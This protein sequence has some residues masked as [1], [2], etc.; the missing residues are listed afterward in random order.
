MTSEEK[1]SNS[2][3][4]VREQPINEKTDSET[5]YNN[6]LKQPIFPESEP[7][8]PTSSANESTATDS[9]TENDSIGHLIAFGGPQR[10]DTDSSIENVTGQNN[11]INVKT[12]SPIKKQSNN[13]H[14][15][16]KGIQFKLPSKKRTQK[17]I[18]RKKIQQRLKDELESDGHDV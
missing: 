14:T 11:K 9:G 1:S 4:S 16:D 15:T 5:E 17:L 13:Y 6:Y 7:E 12:P 10:N 3:R 2:D 18:Y 8:N